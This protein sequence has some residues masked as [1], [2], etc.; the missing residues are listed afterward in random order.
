MD[1]IPVRSDRPPVG[2][3]RRPPV[4]QDRKASLKFLNGNHWRWLRAV[5]LREQP[6]CALHLARG[7]Y[8]PSTVVHHLI[9]RSEAPDL[10]LSAENCQALCAPCHN[11]ITATRLNAARRSR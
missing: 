1:K 10:A 5:V 8:V 7:E 9:D 6:F 3:T 2:L 4:S 11:S